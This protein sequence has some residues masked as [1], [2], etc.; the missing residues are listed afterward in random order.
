M[1]RYAKVFYYSQIENG[2]DLCNSATKHILSVKVW[3]LGFSR[4]VNPP[5]L[6][7]SRMQERK[8]RMRLSRASSAER[9]CGSK[10]ERRRRPE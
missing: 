3:H 8:A 2:P 6:T 1:S 7:L 4:P 9:F 5:V 10:F